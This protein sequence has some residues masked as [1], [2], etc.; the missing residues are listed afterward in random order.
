[1]DAN[2]QY[3]NRL[4]AVSDLWSSRARALQKELLELYQQYLSARAKSPAPLQ[5]VQQ[6]Q[7]LAEALKQMEARYRPPAVPSQPTASEEAR[8]LEQRITDV[9]N[10]LNDVYDQWAMNL[11]LI[12]P[13]PSPLPPGWLDRWLAQPGKQELKGFIARSINQKGLA[14]TKRLTIKKQDG[15]YGLTLEFKW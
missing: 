13:P 1:M 9:G 10:R 15:A 6:V 12:A 14:V 3:A 4:L 7:D 2:E 11:R 5:E 8:R